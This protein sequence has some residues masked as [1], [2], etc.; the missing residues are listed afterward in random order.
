MDTDVAV[1]DR[2]NREG[3][4]ASEVVSSQAGA[5]T[6]LDSL[7]GPN[8]LSTSTPPAGINPSDASSPATGSDT[9]FA[10][11]AS[12]KT[13]SDQDG[14]SSSPVF[15]P[16]LASTSGPDTEASPL[17]ASDGS[18]PKIT[19]Q[20]T[21]RGPDGSQFGSSS[22]AQ[23]SF[24]PRYSHP[25]MSAVP[26]T[27]ASPVTPCFSRPRHPH[28]V[29]PGDESSSS[30]PRE[31]DTEVTPPAG[32]GVAGSIS[33]ADPADED[34]DDH[35]DEK[36]RV[37][38]DG[39]YLDELD[40]DDPDIHPSLGVSMA[41]QATGEPSEQDDSEDVMNPQTGG[42]HGSIIPKV[43][44]IT[45][46]DK[47]DLDETLNS[48]PGDIDVSDPL[49]CCDSYTNSVIR[50]TRKMAKVHYHRRRITHVLAEHR[51]PRANLWR[52][53]PVPVLQPHPKVHTS[54]L[55][56]MFPLKRHLLPGQ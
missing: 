27:L 35:D 24:D 56:R 37:T 22:P 48:L 42:A 49:L 17:A 39:I 53:S 28:S 5:S 21:N 1:D 38:Y 52:L 2:Q 8:R 26:S 55:P 34:G 31:D 11:D 45:S 50:S 44:G 20:S 23:E 7:F 40:V 33:Y 51:L 15:R 14:L 16:G 18:M 47:E 46:V 54:G 19:I 12:P 25:N 13:G 3:S 10:Q 32:L 36:G 29:S 9:T 43:D 41:R 30:T 6:D 4:D